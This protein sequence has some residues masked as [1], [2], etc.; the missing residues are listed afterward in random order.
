MRKVAQ[1]LAFLDLKFSS[2]LIM[3]DEWSRC[4]ICF[5]DYTLE[6]R[7]TTF[8]CGHSTCIDHTVGTKRLRNCAI[9]HG[10]SHWSTI[11]LPTATASRDNAAEM[12]HRDELYARRLQAELLHGRE[13]AVVIDPTPQAS[14]AASA[15]NQPVGYLKNCGHRCDLRT[16]QR[17]C[18]CSDRRPRRQGN[19]YETYVDG[20][21]VVNS[22]A[23][24]E[25]YCSTCKRQ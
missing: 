18:T 4:P 22:A 21:G 14:Q 24:N 11:K 7:P 19:T 5:E 8:T 1:M 6:H 2:K 10:I 17:C 20:R 23:R 9:C 15:Q 25:F 3:N 12:I 16:T 13:R